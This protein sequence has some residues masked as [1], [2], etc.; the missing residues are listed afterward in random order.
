MMG[1]ATVAELRVGMARHLENLDAT[2]ALTL[3]YNDIAISLDRIRA[4]LRAVHGRLDRRLYG[5]RFHLRPPG[6]RTRWWA[7]VEQLRDYPHIH[8]G[9]SLRT[10]QEA[11]LSAMLDDGLWRRFAPGGT[12]NLQPYRTGWASYAA[13]CLT[14]SDHV[15]IDHTIV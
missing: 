12:W 15:L 14:T 5:T 3:T 9:W 10:D 6:Q 13:K 7:V 2:V 11:V 4:D 8:T 1:T